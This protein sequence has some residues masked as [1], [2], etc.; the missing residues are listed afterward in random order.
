MADSNDIR[1]T[2]ES[3][4]SQAGE[5]VQQATA[6]AMSKAQELAGTASRR[7]DEA[8]AALGERVRSAAG[9]IRERGPRE[10]MLGTA[11]GAVAESLESTG[12]YIE[13]EGVLG[14]VEDLT[15]LVRRNPI[16]AMLVG[17][18]IGFMLAKMFRR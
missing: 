9:T 18:G 3:A 17:V 13:E 5:K 8:T 7:V 15:E 2:V 12:R 10:G 14:M 16:P 4:A 1:S 6:A 11:S